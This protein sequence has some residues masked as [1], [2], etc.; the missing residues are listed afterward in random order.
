MDDFFNGKMSLDL[1]ILMKRNS[2]YT[3]NSVKGAK[4]AVQAQ[5]SLIGV[6]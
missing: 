3:L 6:L 4:Y 2:S 5:N 1:N